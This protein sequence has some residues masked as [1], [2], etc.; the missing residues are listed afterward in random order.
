MA[1]SR[2]KYTE[3]Q[4]RLIKELYPISDTF[5]LM[6]IL[7][8]T[9]EQVNHKAYKLGLKKL[10]HV[11][12]QIKR[13]AS[14]KSAGTYKK[15]KAPA[16]TKPVGSIARAQKGYKAIK[17]AEPNVW[18]MLHRKIWEDANGPVPDGMVISYID[19]NK[20][21][22][23]L[24][25]LELIGKKEFFARHTVHNLP[26]ELKELVMLRGNIMRCITVRKRREEDGKE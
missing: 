4:I 22:C 23:V 2:I 16:N 1:R 9:Y 24:E 17:V 21:N 12:K 5:S 26:H 18:V 6:K 14:E 3:E 11:M 25:N 13:E 7:G 8:L 20:E 19:G 15:G 10:P